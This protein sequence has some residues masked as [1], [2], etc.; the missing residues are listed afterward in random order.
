MVFKQKKKICSLSHFI[1]QNSIIR[2]SFLLLNNFSSR[3]YRVLTQQPPQSLG[4]CYSLCLNTHFLLP[5]FPWALSPFT[6]GLSS[7]VQDGFSDHI[8]NNNH[9]PPSRYSLPCSSTLIFAMKLILSKLKLSP[10]ICSAFSSALSCF[11]RS[12]QPDQEEDANYISP[13]GSS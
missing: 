5:P 4:T 9:P 10:H 3:K 2:E 12:V 11:Q 1:A 6:Q 7:N 8:V 13:C